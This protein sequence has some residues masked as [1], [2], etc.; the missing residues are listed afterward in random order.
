MIEINDDNLQSEMLDADKLAL[1]DFSGASCPPCKKLEPIMAELATEMA[2]KV[3]V[4]HCDVASARQTAMRYGVMSIPT[5]V[6]LKSGEEVDRFVGLK[7]KDQILQMIE[8][9]A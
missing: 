5:V 6:F 1:L 3:V 2:E 9:N 8:K 4:G 7:S